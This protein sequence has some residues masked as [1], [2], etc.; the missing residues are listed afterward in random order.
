MGCWRLG[1]GS[2]VRQR[3]VKTG[4]FFLEATTL[5][6]CS[7]AQFSQVLVLLSLCEESLL[8]LDRDGLPCVCGVFLGSSEG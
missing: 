1:D 8:Q 3:G 4:F 7:L 6:A 2:W 5:A